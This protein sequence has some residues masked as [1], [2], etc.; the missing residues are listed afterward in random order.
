MYLSIHYTNNNIYLYKKNHQSL[1]C[2]KDHS[3]TLDPDKYNKLIFL[4]PNHK[5]NDTI[6]LYKNNSLPIS[7]NSSWSISKNYMVDDSLQKNILIP[8]SNL[9]EY[10]ETNPDLTSINS[11]C[12][13]NT[14]ILH[15]PS[16]L[17]YIKDK[18]F[19]FAKWTGFCQTWSSIYEDTDN[20]AYAN[21][22]FFK[23][24]SILMISVQEKNIEHNDFFDLDIMSVDHHPNL[25]HD[26]FDRIDCN[27]HLPKFSTATILQTPINQNIQPESIKITTQYL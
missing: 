20:L 27:N 6:K 15:L 16:V 9:I 10:T 13:D 14:R 23:N 17:C 7:F 18:Q 5:N 24:K 21:L 11:L 22:Y 12:Q 26:E 2:K 1:L 3:Y 19:I 8:P 4:T 25:T